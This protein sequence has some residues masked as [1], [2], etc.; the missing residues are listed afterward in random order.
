MILHDRTRE[1]HRQSE[2]HWNRFKGYGGETAERW[3]GLHL[4]F[5]KRINTILN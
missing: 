2:D 1:G 3:S 5:S 4:G